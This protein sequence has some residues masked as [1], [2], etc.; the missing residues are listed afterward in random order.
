[1]NDWLNTIWIVSKKNSNTCSS[2]FPQNRV[3]GKNMIKMIL[4]GGNAHY[5]NT[6]WNYI[7]F[8]EQALHTHD[9]VSVDQVSSLPEMSF[10]HQPWWLCSWS[11]QKSTT[12]SNPRRHNHF[13][14]APQYNLHRL[15]LYNLNNNWTISICP[16]CY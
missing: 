9:Y 14:S 15:V 5:Y 6:S 3:P 4:G 7:S 8:L 13:L 1:M 10:H 2:F 11:T 16:P 12:F